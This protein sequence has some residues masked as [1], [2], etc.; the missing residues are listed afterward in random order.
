MKV[1]VRYS[2]YDKSMHL[3]YAN[4]LGS[5]FKVSQPVA[6]KKGTYYLSIAKADINKGTGSYTFS[7][8]HAKKL[9]AAPKIK[10]V[11]NSSNGCMTV[12]W[13]SVTGATGYELWYST[14]PNFKSGVEK[15]ELNAS[16]TSE[17]YSW[18]TLK[19]RYYV[20]IRAFREINGMKEYGKW[21]SRKSVVIKK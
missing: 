19:K 21:S 11:R 10:S 6:V 8:D 3:A 2:V 9:S 1:F 13:S 14:S 5:G 7:I 18:L 12:K 15:K 4:T 16:Q 20:R 17:T